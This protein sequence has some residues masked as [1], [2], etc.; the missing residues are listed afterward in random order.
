MQ[1]TVH[2]CNH[3]NY[4]FCC[5]AYPIRK[6]V[7][8]HYT[9]QVGQSVTL[10]MGVGE[11]A[12]AAHYTP[13]WSRNGATLENANISRGEDFSLY[14]GAVDLSDA[15]DYTSSVTVDAEGNDYILNER[16]VMLTVF[17]KFLNASKKYLHTR[18]TRCFVAL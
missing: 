9:I 11:G 17:G 8:T 1:S 16:H 13:T 10:L 7:Q 14:I 12:L 18:T 2:A 4:T 3:Y 5:I 6:N 15:G